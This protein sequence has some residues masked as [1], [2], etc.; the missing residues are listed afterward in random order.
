MS[1]DNGITDANT[2]LTS[3]DNQLGN[4]TTA[5]QSIDI[6]TPVQGQATMAASSPVVI[7]SNQSAIP[8]S[9]PLTDTQLRAIAV[10]VSLTSTTITGSVAVTG[11]LTDTQLRATPVPVSGT[12]STGGLTDTQLRASPVPVSLTSTTITGTVAA[13]QSGTWNITNVS[14]T[15]SLPTG[16]ATETTLAAASAKFPTTLGQKTMANS[17]AV[18]IASDQTALPVS[19]SAV[20]SAT[21]SNVTASASSVTLA[22]SSSTRRG[23]SVYNDSTV[24]L[25]LKFGATASVTSFTVLLIAGAYYEM[26]SDTIYTGVI[27]GIW[28]SATGTARVTVY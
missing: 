26:P 23:F 3:I 28:T 21:L 19:Q 20:A 5:V 12:V 25:Y 27:D 13:T 14:G 9:G 1:V 22:A 2:T 10:P 18:A 7:A 8:V 17:L 6:K 11:P 15:V 16:A 4:V 24:T